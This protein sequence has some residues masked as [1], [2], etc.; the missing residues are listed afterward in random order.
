MATVTASLRRA[1]ER[2]GLTNEE[3]AAKWRI[4]NGTLYAL[5]AGAEIGSLR[6]ARK[7]KA[8]GVTVPGSVLDAA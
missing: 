2:Q 3:F 5:L 1:I 4:S 7:L 6:T 8:A